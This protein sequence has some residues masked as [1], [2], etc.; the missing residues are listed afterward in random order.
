VAWLE[1]QGKELPRGLALNASGE[2]MLPMLVGTDARSGAVAQAY[3]VDANNLTLAGGDFDGFDMARLWGSEYV[4]LLSGLDELPV[5]VDAEILSIL[6][7][8]YDFPETPEEF[9]KYDESVENDVEWAECPECG[10]K[11]PL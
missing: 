5:S 8:S 2:W 1:S 10:H 11:W 3:A 4:D 6:V 9:A 7:A